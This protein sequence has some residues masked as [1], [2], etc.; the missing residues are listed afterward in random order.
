MITQKEGRE[1]HRNFLS[2][3]ITEKKQTAAAVVYGK[4]CRGMS[5]V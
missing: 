2:N 5:F 3:T 4:R 1:W